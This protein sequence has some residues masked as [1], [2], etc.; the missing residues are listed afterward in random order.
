MKSQAKVF[1]RVNHVQNLAVDLVFFDCWGFPVGNP[2]NFTLIQ[3][4]LPELSTSHSWIL[5]RLFCKTAWS[6]GALIL[7]YIYQSLAFGLEHVLSNPCCNMGLQ[8]PL[9]D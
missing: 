7:L 9:C 6:F 1:C 8:N 5:L 2:Y 4:E 3:V